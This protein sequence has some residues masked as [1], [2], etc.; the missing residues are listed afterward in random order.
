MSARPA[1]PPRIHV[2]GASGS[3]TTTLGRRVARS[4]GVPDLDADH[5]YWEPTDPPFLTKRAPEARVAMIE[6]TISDADG[7]VLSGSL[8]GWGDPLR[9]RFTL[10]VFLRLDPA[11]RLERLKAREQARY[12]SRV[13]PRGDMYQ[14]HLEFMNWAASYDTATA[15]TRS[16]DLHE[17]WLAELSCPVLRLDSAEPVEGLADKVLAA[18]RGGY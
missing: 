13:T 1:T 11:V 8:C 18:T 2:F 16:L 10:A 4:L 5:F 14:Q 9:H 7:W 3:G 17:R 12:G 6:Q 15:P